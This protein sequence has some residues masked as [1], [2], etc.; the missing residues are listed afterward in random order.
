MTNGRAEVLVDQSSGA[1]GRYIQSQDL[2]N[3]PQ[4]SAAA[5]DDFTITAPYRITTLHAIG[6]EYYGA[7]SYNLDVVGGIYTEPDMRIA[8]IVRVSGVQ[9]GNDLFFDFGGVVLPAGQYWIGAWIVRP[10]TFGG[11]YYNLRMPINGSEA[12]WHNPGGGHGYGTEPVTMGSVLEQSDLMFILSG[13]R[14]ILPTPTATNFSPP[15]PTATATAVAPTATATAVPP[16]PTA[17]TRASTPTNTVP[18]ATATRT[19][20]RT[21]TPIGGV[22][23]GGGTSG[24]GG[25]NQGNGNN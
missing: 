18:T 9:V 14:A 8:P 13:D 22:N 10:N 16:S 15:Q 23:Q 20:T 19:R 21:P 25:G 2:T 4:Y 17:T 12:R 7:P 3:Q 6:R 24:N 5:F 11:W 1:T